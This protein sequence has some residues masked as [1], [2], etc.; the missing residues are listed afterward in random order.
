MSY[1]FICK[2]CGNIQKFNYA[3]GTIG[4]KCDNCHSSLDWSNSFPPMTAID[5]INSAKDLFQQSKNCNKENL[6][7]QYEVIKNEGKYSINK[8][9]LDSLNNKYEKL[10]EK[11]NDNDDSLWQ[12]ISDKFQD[13]LCSIME[14]NQ[15]IAI[16]TA[17][18]LFKHN[19][20][21]K[22]FIIM[23]ASIIEQ[24]FNDYFEDVIN[25]SLSKYGKKV[26]MEKYYTAGIQSAIDISSSFLDES[27]HIKM[28]RYSKGFY[29]KWAGLRTL[30]NN[31]IHSNNKYIS[32]NK[33]SQINKLI[34]ESYLVFSSLKSELYRK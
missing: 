34:E 30:R 14:Q 8:T 33:V 3:Q 7:N 19:H 9:V 1:K 6:N 21:R 20:Y 16:S 13:N 27:L 5:F 28:D 15:A 24:L 4:L 11:Y 17:I 31:I 23:V 10:C 2:E 29:D 22:P 12:E 26:F 25:V 18:Q 32:K